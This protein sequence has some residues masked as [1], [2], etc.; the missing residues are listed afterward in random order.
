MTQ[1]CQRCH[2][3]ADHHC[4]RCG[5]A[6]CEPCLLDHGGGAHECIDQVPDEDE[7][8]FTVWGVL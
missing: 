1:N 7:T 4:G 6:V 2:Q 8:T 5:Y 3:P